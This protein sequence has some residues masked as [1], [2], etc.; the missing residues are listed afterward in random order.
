[1]AHARA[2]LLQFLK[3]GYLGFS[4]SIK[5]RIKMKQFLS[6]LLAAFFLTACGQTEFSGDGSSEGVGAKGVVS[7]VNPEGAPPANEAIGDLEQAAKYE[8][9]CDKKGGSKKV[10]VCHVPEG[11][12]ENRHTL[13]L[14]Q[15]AIDAHLAQHDASIAG[16]DEDYLGECK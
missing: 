2:P 8:C 3:R 13:C 12:P 5:G 15:S 11:N 9:G 10:A 1:L 14:P 16:G 4:K 7:E 6:V